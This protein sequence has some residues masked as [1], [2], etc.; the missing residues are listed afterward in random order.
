[1]CFL[2]TSTLIVLLPKKDS[3]EK[4][5]IY[6]SVI[7]DK[8]RKKAMVNLLRGADFQGIIDLFFINHSDQPIKVQS[9]S[10]SEEWWREA[11]KLIK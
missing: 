2:L 10:C 11:T 6:V 8:V 1:M 9:L 5:Q 3:I 7:D 4:V